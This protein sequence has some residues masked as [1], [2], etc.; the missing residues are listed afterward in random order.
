[1][2]GPQHRKLGA[3]AGIGLA[4]ALHAP[5]WQVPV[6]VVIAAGTSYGYASPD[7]D[8]APWWHRMNRFLPDEWFCEGGFLD[9]RKITHWPGL[10][11]IAGWL[12]LA[13]LP[14]VAQAPYLALCAAWLSHHVG[15]FLFGHGGI[16]LLPWGSCRVGLELDQDGA[17]AD[18]TASSVVP[19]TLGVLAWGALGWPGLARLVERL[20]DLPSL[21]V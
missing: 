21:P 8:Q 9:H 19:L 14:P 6:I 18:R 12:A 20:P 17:L 4:A 2:N 3:A 13:F 11:L 15:D 16:P 7:V 10:P 5:W 1:M